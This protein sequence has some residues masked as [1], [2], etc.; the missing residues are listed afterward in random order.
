MQEQREKD[1][2]LDRLQANVPVLM[3][4]LK[5]FGSVSQTERGIVLV[6]P[7]NY[8]KGTRLST[9]APNGEANV[10]SLSDVL[11]NSTD[12]KVSSKRTPTTTERRTNC[13]L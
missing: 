13:K 4:S 2:K 12:Y 1:Q 11:A 10:S 8:W 9:F 7:E 3:E 5:R 6:L